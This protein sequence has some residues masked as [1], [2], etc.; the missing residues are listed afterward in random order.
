MPFLHLDG[1]LKLKGLNNPSVGNGYVPALFAAYK[2]AVAK[3]SR[4]FE[5]SHG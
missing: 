2:V 3:L 4:Y 5:G 1:A